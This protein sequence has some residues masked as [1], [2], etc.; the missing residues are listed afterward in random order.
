MPTRS[1]LI[2][3]GRT[4]AE[5]AREIGA[6]RLIYQD[7]EA[8]EAAILRLNPLIST[9]D[10]SC[11]NGRYVTG[12]VTPEYLDALEIRRSNKSSKPGEEEENTQQMALGL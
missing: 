10:S 6:D 12:D 7:I 9:L 8:L 11:F 1:E 5:I 4:D 3:T 2:A